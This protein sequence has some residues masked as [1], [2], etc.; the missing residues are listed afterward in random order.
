[1]ADR[2]DELYEKAKQAIHDLHADTSVPQSRTRD[3]LE[4]LGEEIST[5]IDSLTG[6]GD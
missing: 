4:N 1:M 5:L 2:H 6:L 3:S